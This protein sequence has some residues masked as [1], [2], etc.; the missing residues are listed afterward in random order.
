MDEQLSLSMVAIECCAWD[1]EVNHCGI[2]RSQRTVHNEPGIQAGYRWTGCK[3]DSNGMLWCRLPVVYT[4]SPWEEGLPI[5]TLESTHYG[6]DLT[7]TSHDF[8]KPHDM[9]ITF[10]LTSKTKTDVNASSERLSI[11]NG[12]PSIVFQTRLFSP[13]RQK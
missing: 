10:K 9:I 5:R 7:V 11:W 13:D 1:N 3:I 4:G 12:G 6:G 8:V 2:G